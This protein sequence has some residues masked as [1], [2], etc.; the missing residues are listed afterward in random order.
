MSKIKEGYVLCDNNLDL[1]VVCMK[2]VIWNVL[3]ELI[4]EKGFDVII[5]KDII[6]KVNIN[7]GIFYVYY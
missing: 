6:M 4:E 1:C 3:V 5:V 7:C 2:I